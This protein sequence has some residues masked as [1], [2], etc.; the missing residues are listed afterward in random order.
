MFQIRK[1]ILSLLKTKTRNQ[2]KNKIKQKQNKRL[3]HVQQLDLQL[4]Q[5]HFTSHPGFTMVMVNH[6]LI[7]SILLTAI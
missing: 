2:N 6:Y 1:T 4:S 5:F 3:K 7:L